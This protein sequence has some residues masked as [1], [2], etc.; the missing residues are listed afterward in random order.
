[1]S[2]PDAFPSA[3]LRALLDRLIPAD[4]FPGC[5]AAGGENYVGRQL[6]G[7]CSAE[8]AGLTHGL[9]LLDAEAKRRVAGKTFASLTSD[10]QDSLLRELECGRACEN[11]PAE[12]SAT[13]FLTRMIDL[14]HEGF[15]ADPGNGGNHDAVSW[16]MI[17]YNPR[18]PPELAT[19]APKSSS[20][21]QPRLPSTPASVSN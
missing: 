6:N 10:Q 16:R 4:E 11:W 19:I 5:V 20:G 21:S 2:F 15:Y 9:A 7:T 1:M 12:L 8:A 14:A 13:A 3:T 18:L 17:G